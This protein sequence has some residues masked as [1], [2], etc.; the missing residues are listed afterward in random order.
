MQF[1]LLIKRRFG[2]VHQ[3]AANC[4]LDAW[5]DAPLGRLAEII[6]LDQFSRNIY[7]DTE[8]AFTND[9]LALALAQEAVRQKAD[10]QVDQVMRSF[11]LYALYA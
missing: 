9:A 1:D 11:F 5:R 7:R 8:N 6:V 4:E 2:E 3:Q 10:L